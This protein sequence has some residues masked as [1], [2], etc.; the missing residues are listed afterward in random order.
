MGMDMLAESGLFEICTPVLYYSNRSRRHSLC[1]KSGSY[2]LKMC[3]VTSVTKTWS[4][5]LPLVWALM[6]N[7]LLVHFNRY[8]ERRGIVLVS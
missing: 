7:E 4:A 5:A 8:D 3:K 2:A 1:M 6:V